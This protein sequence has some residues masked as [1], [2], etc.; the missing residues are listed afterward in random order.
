VWPAAVETAFRRRFTYRPKGD[1]V[2]GRSSAGWCDPERVSDP[3]TWLEERIAVHVI[4]HTQD[5]APEPSRA[6]TSAIISAEYPLRVL[7][8]THCMRL[9]RRQT[10]FE[11]L[12]TSVFCSSSLEDALYATYL[13]ESI[14]FT[15]TA[16]A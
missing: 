1:G 7:Q 16:K 13:S 15:A 11:E 14:N 5:T 10:R 6:A 3:K 2:G 12:P 8:E 4:D 9:Q